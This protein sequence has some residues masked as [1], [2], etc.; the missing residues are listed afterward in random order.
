MDITLSPSIK[1]I[2][3]R[4]IRII[5]FTRRVLPLL[6]LETAAVAL[7]ARQLAESIFFN[8]VLQN[9]IVHTF[10]HSPV[11][12]L[13]FFFRAFISTESI[14]QILMLGSLLVASLFARDTFRTLRAFTLKSNLSTLSRV[15]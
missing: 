8:H 4:R 15:I 2:V 3:M 12:I 10:S 6:V 7:I 9:A 14:V 13:D 5:W 11:M 1:K